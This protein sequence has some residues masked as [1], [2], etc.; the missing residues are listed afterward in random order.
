MSYVA[1]SSR[2]EGG[3]SRSVEC[4]LTSEPSLAFFPLPMAIADRSTLASFEMV[5]IVRSTLPPHLIIIMSHFG[6]FSIE[7]A[8][9]CLRSTP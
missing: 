3:G 5:N 2:I 8:R 9:K 7:G 6:T 1:S 4:H